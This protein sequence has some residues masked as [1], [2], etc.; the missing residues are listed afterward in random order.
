VTVANDVFTYDIEDRRIGKSTS[1]TQTWT[2]YN[3]QQVYA[4]FNSGGSLTMRYLTGK[5]LD[6]LFGR[7]DGTAATWYLTDLIGS[8]RMLTNNSGTN[9]DQLSYD[10]Y[11]NILT[12]T[13]SAN[14]DR[15]KYTARDWDS[16]IGLQYNRAR[17]YDPKAGRWI[18]LDP[19][20]FDAGALNLY[21]YVQNEP[22][23]TSDPTGLQAK[24]N[25]TPA[26]QFMELATL[27]GVPRDLVA[28]I[29]QTAIQTPVPSEQRVQVGIWPPKIIFVHNKCEQWA[30]NV[31]NAITNDPLYRAYVLRP[32]SEQG[33]VCI[34]MQQYA[35][36]DWRGN[37]HTVLFVVFK[38]GGVGLIDLGTLASKQQRVSV[39]AS[40]EMAIPEGW[41]RIY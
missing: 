15:F 7:Y 6:Q 1:G 34:Q 26:Q 31:Y 3:G 18:S 25:R 10:G 5:A 23:T 14:G 27:N 29:L 38:K 35:L 17:Y 37:T 16:E 2:F 8:V 33:I 12:E 9:L 21:R 24:Q 32:A 30:I 19:L 22:L 13:N 39:Y 36:N 28:M 41:E 40:K 4:D 11:G 20:G